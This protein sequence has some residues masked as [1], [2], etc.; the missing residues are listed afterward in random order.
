MTVM[1]AALGMLALTAQEAPRCDLSLI[2]REPH[3][4]PGATFQVALKFKIEPGWHIYWQNAGDTGVP[5]NVDWKLP[6]G[7]KLEKTEWSRPH[8]FEASDIVSYGYEGQGFIVATIKAPASSDSSAAKI[9][10]AA[11]WLICRESCVMGKG[12]KSLSIPVR[13]TK[14][15]GPANPRLWAD[16]MGEMPSANRLPLSA[17][18]KKDAYEIFIGQPKFSFLTPTSAYF[19]AKASD[20]ADHGKPQTIRQTGEGT[21]LRIP[22]S[23]FEKGAAKVLEGVLQ[24]GQGEAQDAAI[25]VRIPID[26]TSTTRRSS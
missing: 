6:A 25:S 4:Q 8:R 1:L 17:S 19:F 9:T 5:T 15:A 24:L 23:P 18:V 12:T 7:F 3:V 26:T 21:V 11:D 14:A 10:A 20:V 16:V 2:V 22:R 13:K